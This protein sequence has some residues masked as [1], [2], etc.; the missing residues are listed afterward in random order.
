[1]TSSTDNSDEREG[2]LPVTEEEHPA[3]TEPGDWAPFAIE[4]DAEQ[5]DALYRQALE[6]M[7][8]VEHEA[9]IATAEGEDEEAEPSEAEPSETE[10]SETGDAPEDVQAGQPESDDAADAE[11]SSFHRL[12]QAHGDDRV[13]PAKIIEAA[14][15]V[16]GTQLTAKKLRKLLGGSYPDDF[17]EQT[18][19]ELNRQYAEENRPYEILFGEGGYRM[20]LKSEFDRVR[21]RVFGLGPKEIKLS[22]EAL[23]TLS[24]IAYRQPITP[25]EIDKLRGQ[26]TAGTLR[27]LIR[28]E[29]VALERDPEN[30]KHV[31][32]RTTPRFLEVFGLSQLAELPQADDLNFK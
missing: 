29:L 14:L 15:F 27:Q 32:Y 2:E 5:L 26:P 8:S 21:N 19:D 25:G 30:R 17:V 20:A 7:E 1:M 18:I 4:A 3:E 28:R 23:E 6:A 12:D 24:L 9:E 31:E 11:T 22:Q 10:S 13:S 16:G